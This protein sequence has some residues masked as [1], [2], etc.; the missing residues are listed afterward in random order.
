M[1]ISVEFESIDELNEFM[2]WK[3]ELVRKSENAKKTPL[4][5]VD[6]DQRTV[7]ILHAENIVFLE[8]AQALSDNQLLS[9]TNFGK[10]A[11]QRLRALK[12]EEPARPA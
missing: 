9:F 12:K 7:N 8:D 4:K 3:S 10:V 11:L 6:L 1:K 5:S 2:K